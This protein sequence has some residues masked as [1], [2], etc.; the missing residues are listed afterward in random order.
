MEV[1]CKIKIQNMKRKDQNNKFRTFTLVKGKNDPENEKLSINS[2]L[3]KA[4]IDTQVGDE[5]E[6]QIGS[7]IQLVKILQVD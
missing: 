6:Y 3:G 4:L 7:E 5:V 1:G 2:P